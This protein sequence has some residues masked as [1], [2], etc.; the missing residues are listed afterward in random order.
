MTKQVIFTAIALIATIILFEFSDLD[1][2]VQDYFYNTQLQQW[3]ISED[4]ALLDLI[5]YSGI[6]KIFIAFAASLLLALIFFYNTRLIQSYKQGIIIVLLSLIIIP[7]VIGLLKAV[8]NVPCPNDLALYDGNYPHVTFLSA[9]PENFIQKKKVKCFPAG[10]ASGGFALMSLFFFFKTQRNKR[11][12]LASAL[13][14]GWSTGSYK[15]FIGDH[16]LSHTVVTMLIAW[17]LIIIIVKGV[18]FSLP[19]THHDESDAS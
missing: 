9:Y 4:N 6:K 18:R 1:L 11:I 12:A 16:F 13:V 17:L 7:S 8:T 5:F 2:Q 10:H 3:L 19:K 14:I 15:M